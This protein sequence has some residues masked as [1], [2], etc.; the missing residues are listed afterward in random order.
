MGCHI[1]CHIMSQ[2][3]VTVFS[4]SVFTDSI[5]IPHNRLALNNKI[6]FNCW[7]IK[8]RNKHRW[9]LILYSIVHPTQVAKSKVAH[10]R[11]CAMVCLHVGRQHHQ[12]S[13]WNV[14][15]HGRWSPLPTV[16]AIFLHGH[17]VCS[18][19]EPH[20]QRLVVG[21]MQWLP[22]VCFRVC[23]SASITHLDDERRSGSSVWITVSTD[24]IW[25]GGSS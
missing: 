9:S 23:D 22:C 18:Q 7:Q 25:V 19:L 3:L 14:L 24:C 6:K 15:S 2:L 4:R 10:E 5:H 20:E 1:I 17:T 12:V 13:Q 16:C 11:L 21:G 8:L